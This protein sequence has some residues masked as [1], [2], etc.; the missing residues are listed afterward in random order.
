[1]T[2]TLR[3]AGPEERHDDGTPGPYVRHLRQQ[4]PGRRDPADARTPRYGPDGRPDPGPGHRRAGPA[5]RPRHG[6]RAGRRGSAARLGLPAD[7]GDRPGRGRGRPAARRG[8]GLHRAQP[9]G[10][11]SPSTEPPPLPEGSARPGAGRGGVPGLAGEAALAGY[12]RTQLGQGMPRDTRRG[13]RRRRAPRPAA[14]RRGHARPGAADPRPRRRRTSA[15]SGSRC[16]C[17]TQPGGY[18]VDVTGGAR[19]PR[20]AATA[21]P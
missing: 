10:W 21:A 16:G 3:P 11:P 19:T 4:P 12:V 20:A 15:P 1:M 7:R 6:R 13:D 8:A 2:T 17:R 5:P 9:R 18:V 14:G